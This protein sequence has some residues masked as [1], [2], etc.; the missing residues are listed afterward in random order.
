MK[1]LKWFSVAIALVAI[2]VVSVV[3]VISATQI[4]EH[5]RTTDIRD[6]AYY[7]YCLDVFKTVVVGLIVGALGVVIPASL[8][9]S[10]DKF[11]RLKASRAAFSSAKTGADYLSLR[12]SAAK[13]SKAG[14]LIQEVHFQK[15]QAQL[16]DK[17]LKHH[18]KLRY[19]PPVSLKDW[20]EVMYRKLRNAR[21]VL[22]QNAST[23]DSLQPGERLDLLAQALPDCDETAKDYRDL[24]RRLM[25]L[26]ERVNLLVWRHGIRRT[27]SA[28]DVCSRCG[29]LAQPSELAAAGSKN[30][31]PSAPS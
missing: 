12:L 5:L 25:H 4:I 15:H 22:K 21:Q 6:A 11:D 28:K 3:A 27:E 10:R 8:A 1:I 18:L 16:Y 2:L 7:K 13:L 29:Q 19:D 14:S 24:N 17:E 23:W 26:A 20:D 30:S 31:C 9:Y